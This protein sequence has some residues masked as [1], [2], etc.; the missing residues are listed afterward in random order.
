MFN[1]DFQKLPETVSTELL[2]F[3]KKKLSLTSRLYNELTRP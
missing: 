3:D 1:D 2:Y